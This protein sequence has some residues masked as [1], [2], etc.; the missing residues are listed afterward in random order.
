MERRVVTATDGTE[1]VLH[2]GLRDRFGDWFEERPERQP[3][4]MPWE[5]PFARI[6]K[7]WE[8]RVLRYRW[9]LLAV[10]YEDERREALRGPF[11][12]EEQARQAADAMAASVLREG[13]PA[14]TR[15][16]QPDTLQ[17]LPRWLRS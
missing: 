12:S 6:S 14:S 17:R 15:P 10:W 9:W 16:Q 5:R 3:G 8:A 7:A 13:P 2:F 4:W 11:D 1:V